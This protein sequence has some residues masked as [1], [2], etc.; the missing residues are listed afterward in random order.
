MVYYKII[1]EQGNVYEFDS[2]PEIDDMLDIQ[3]ELEDGYSCEKI[4]PEEYKRLQSSVENPTVNY[5]YSSAKQEN[6]IVS[7]LTNPQ[8]IKLLILDFFNSF[9]I[10]PDVEELD[11]YYKWFTQPE[12]ED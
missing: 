5:T 6:D 3:N 7:N 10:S 9:S 8:R 1:D 4:E 2:V 11:K 12:K